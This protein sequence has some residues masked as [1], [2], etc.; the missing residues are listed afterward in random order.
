MCILIRQKTILII[1]GTDSSGGAGLARDV[2]VA[3][4]LGLGTKPVVTAVTAQHDHAVTQLEMMSPALVAAQIS[5]AFE[6]Q[7]PNAVKIGMLGNAALVETVGEV[8]AGCKVPIVLDPVI[9]TSSGGRLISEDGVNLLKETLLPQVDLVTPNIAEAEIL[10][11]AELK[12][13]CKAILFK[14]GHGDG[15]RLLDRLW[16]GGREVCFEAERQPFTPRGTGCS[17]AT[18]IACRLANGFALDVA[19]GQ[20]HQYVQDWISRLQ[21]VP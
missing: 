20:A 19:I 3:T 15:D 4:E 21:P 6:D 11:S 2:A 10:G 5:A 18:A 16:H 12:T 9:A 1:G 8:L 14:G 17:L 7:S 13:I